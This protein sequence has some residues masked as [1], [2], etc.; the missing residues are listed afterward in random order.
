MKQPLPPAF[1]LFC[2]TRGLNRYTAR[3]IKAVRGNS[4]HL[5]LYQVICKM[6][7]L[8]LDKTLVSLHFS[9]T[10]WFSVC[11]LH[12]DFHF[13]LLIF[14]NVFFDVIVFGIKEGANGFSLMPCFSAFPNRPNYSSQDFPFKL[15]K[16]S[17]GSLS[18][19]QCLTSISNYKPRGRH[20]QLDVFILL[21]TKWIFKI[22]FNENHNS[23]SS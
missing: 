19:S 8:I 4:H 15:L 23:P 5:K 13:V 17:S 2:N 6:H 14:F 9:F 21:F 11:L 1:P 20:I 3:D 10:L 16:S 12:S 7:Y 22:L 18:E